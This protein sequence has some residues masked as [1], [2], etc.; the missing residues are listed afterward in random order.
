MAGLA[1]TQVHSHPTEADPRLVPAELSLE[2]PDVRSRRPPSVP[3]G[4]R[5]AVRRVP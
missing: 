2:I 3:A 1:A 4:Q 5:L